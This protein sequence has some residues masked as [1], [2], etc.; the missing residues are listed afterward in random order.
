MATIEKQI[1]ELRI[2]HAEA[3]ATAANLQA[4]TALR[5]ATALRNVL[6]AR[7]MEFGNDY[8]KQLEKMPPPPLTDK[9]VLDALEL[10]NKIQVLIENVQSQLKGKAK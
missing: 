10:P 8:S 6:V 5:M 2:L 3:I 7:S 4:Q 1:T 9:Q